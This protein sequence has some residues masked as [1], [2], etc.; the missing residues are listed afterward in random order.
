MY[1]AVRGTGLGKPD[2]ALG[3]LARTV[4]TRRVGNLKPAQF[5]NCCQSKRN[6]VYW[7]GQILVAIG[8]FVAGMKTLCQ[9]SLGLFGEFPCLSRHVQLIGLPA[10]AQISRPPETPAI[11]TDLRRSQHLLAL[12]LQLGPNGFD[13]T[14]RE[15]F[16]L[17]VERSCIV[18]SD[19]CHHQS[20]R[21]KA[22]R[23]GGNDDPGDVEFFSERSSVHRP[24]SPKSDQTEF[25][26]IMTALD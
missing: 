26:R 3:F 9:L 15:I 10:V 23:D 17:S 11:R 22:A 16:E 18:P 7:F 13:I 20:E 8:L 6:Q 1:A 5:S 4:R 12:S 14:G 19:I 25:P 24:C 2:R 21:G